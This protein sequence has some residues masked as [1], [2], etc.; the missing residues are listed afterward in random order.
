MPL[1]QCPRCRTMTVYGAKDRPPA[2]CQECRAD[3]A[4]GAPP[5]DD[6]EIVFV[7]FEDDDEEPQ[8]PRTATKDASR[9]AAPEWAADAALLGLYVDDEPAT[10]VSWSEESCVVEIRDILSGGGSDPL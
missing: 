8:T 4:T 3:F 7:E 6:P 10:T 1:L 9:G 5:D 2:R